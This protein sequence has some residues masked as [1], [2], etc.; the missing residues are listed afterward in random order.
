[1]K[2]GFI[3]QGKVTTTH[4]LLPYCKVRMLQG[5]TLWGQT[6]KGQII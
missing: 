4:F 1:M 5:R 3:L 6:A 2:G